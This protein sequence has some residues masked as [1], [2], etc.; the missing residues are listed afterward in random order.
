MLNTGLVR[1]IDELGRIVIPKEIRKNLGIKSGEEIEIYIEENNII[2]KKFHRLLNFKEL[3]GN[4]VDLFNKILP[5]SLIIT[6]C[7][8]I[9]L[10]NKNEYKIFESKKISLSLSKTFE[11]RKDVIGVNLNISDNEI[12]KANYYIKPVII[13]TD[14]IGSIIC[15]SDKEISKEE[16]LVVDIMCALFRIKFETD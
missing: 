5:I 15:F 13:N 10:T 8:S 16:K 11:E 12:I 3:V 7:E 9:I 2:L 1:K 6:D 4:Y 14:L